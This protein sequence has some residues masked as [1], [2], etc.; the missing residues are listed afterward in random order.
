MKFNQKKEDGS[1]DIQFSWKERWLIFIKGNLHL[2]PLFFKHFTNI[3]IKV[4]VEW[5]TNF[6]EKIKDILS[7]STDV[8]K[9][10]EKTQK[11]KSDNKA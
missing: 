1:C 11:Q 7:Y 9:E 5:Q 4:A 2:S 6:D 8:T 10:V 3:L